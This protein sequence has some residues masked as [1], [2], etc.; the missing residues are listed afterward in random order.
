MTTATMVNPLLLILHTPSSLLA[1]THQTAKLRIDPAKKK[2]PNKKNQIERSD[3]QVG[4][5]A[6]AWQISH[7]VCS[8]LL[9]ERFTG[10]N[11]RFA[12]SAPC[13]QGLSRVPF[14]CGPSPVARLQTFRKLHMD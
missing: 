2:A 3:S 1:D 6:T 5:K 4:Q 11:N 7:P 12:P 9:P 10:S 14:I 8:V 13:W